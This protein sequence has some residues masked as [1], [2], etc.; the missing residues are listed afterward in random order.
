MSRNVQNFVSAVMPYRMSRWSTGEVWLYVFYY[1][2]FLKIKHRDLSSA[3]DFFLPFDMQPRHGYE[4]V[5]E[6]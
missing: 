6:K 1:A 2:S 3:D 5:L 4:L